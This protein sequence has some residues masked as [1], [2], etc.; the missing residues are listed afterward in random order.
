DA[1]ARVLVKLKIKSLQ[2]QLRYF[3]EPP[4]PIKQD[5]EHVFISYSRNDS[6]YAYRLVEKMTD[7]GFVPWIDKRQLGSSDEWWESIIRALREC[8]AFVIIMT[9]EAR[10]SKWV[11]KELMLAQEWNKPTFPL[12]LRGERWEIFVDIQYDDV[13]DGL[14]PSSLFWER[15]A[16]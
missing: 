14:L 8:A 9:P 1:I 12:L 5:I 16:K 2:D 6:E 15:L 3:Q 10:N 7:R 11:N 4:P 13:R